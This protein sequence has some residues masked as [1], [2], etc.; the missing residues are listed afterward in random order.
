MKAIKSILLL[1][2]VALLFSS[3]NE[4]VAKSLEAFPA[5]L[6]KANEIVVIADKN[7]WEGPE[8]DSLRFYFASAYPMMP[9][10]EPMFD[11]R[12]FTPLDL[13]ANVL[14]RELRTYI[15]LGDL[16]D[17]TS[18][19]SKMIIKDL[20]EQRYQEA[21]KGEGFD[22]TVG[23]NKWARGQL[24]IYLFGK[25]RQSLPEV[26]RTRFPSAAHRVY[27]HDMKQLKSNAYAAGFN[28]LIQNE[29]KNQMNVD[30]KIPAD[31]IKAM[32]NEEQNLFWFRKETSDASMNIAI[33][34]LAYSSKDQLTEE[35]IKS[36]INEYGEEFVKTD[37]EGSYWQINDRDLPTYKNTKDQNGN[38]TVEIRGIWEMTEDFMGGPYFAYAILGKDKKELLIVN[39]FVDA[40]SKEKRDLMQQLDLITSTID[41]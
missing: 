40:P 25:D 13:E 6:G 5:A 9:R 10:P 37:T 14:R 33:R 17:K 11:L 24:V 22:S 21:L 3:C 15:L 20:G 41:F 4:E 27:Q 26:I 29:L 39:C 32:F 30:F 31:Y 38:Y 12:H 1:G 16:S 7:I 28:P 8:G 2:A 18:A 23:Q 35:Y 36:S 34:K 19:T